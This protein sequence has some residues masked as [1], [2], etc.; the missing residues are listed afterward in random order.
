MLIN[1]RT[2]KLI[3]SI[4]EVKIDGRMALVS[5]YDDLPH[6]EYDLTI[7]NLENSIKKLK[8]LIQELNQQVKKLENENSCFKSLNLILSKNISSL[9]K[10]AKYEIQRKDKI[11]EELRKS[12]MYATATSKMFSYSNSLPLEK[13]QNNQYSNKNNDIEHVITVT[14][15]SNILNENNKDNLT[16]VL[17]QPNYNIPKTVYN[18]RLCKKLVQQNQI[19]ESKNKVPISIQS[20]NIISTGKNT[21]DKN[22]KLNNDKNVIKGMVTPSIHND[23]ENNPNS[24]LI[25]CKSD[26]TSND[27]LYNTTPI[28]QFENSEKEKENVSTESFFTSLKQPIKIKKKMVIAPATIGVPNTLNE[29]LSKSRNLV[30]E[31]IAEEKYTEENNYTKLN[32]VRK[33]SHEICTSPSANKELNSSTRIVKCL[34]LSNEIKSPFLTK[35]KSN[36]LECKSPTI[37]HVNNSTESIQLNNSVEHKDK[38]SRQSLPD[39]TGIPSTNIEVEQVPFRRKT[40]FIGMDNTKTNVIRKSS[41]KAC[42]S[43]SVNKEFNAS[44]SNEIKSPIS[45]KQKNSQLESKSFNII[46]VNNSKESIKLTDSV[47]DS[48]KVKSSRPS[49]PD[50]TSIPSTNIE[51]E[52]VPFKRKTI[53]KEM[54]NNT[55]LNDVK[56]SSHETCTSP[57]VDKKFNISTRVVKCLSLSNEIKS[58]IS[59]KKKNSQF[60][61]KSPTINHV[62]NST[63]SI[64]LNNS[65]EHKDKSSRQSLPDQTGIPSTNIEVEQVPFRRKT[66]FIGMD[67]TKTNVIRKS[68]HKACTSSSVNKE[69]NASPSN[70]I[71]SPISYKQKNSQLESKSF[72]I[73]KVN[74]SK[75]SIKLTDSVDDSSK[76]KSSR[77][78]L[79]DQ[80]SIPS[81]NIE[82][83][84]VPFKRKTIVKEMDNNT[85]LNDVKKSSHET[86]TSPS[87][88]KKFNIST[89]VVKCLSLSNEIKSP[90]SSKKKNS[91]FEC[92]SPTINHVNN[93]TE[94]IQLNDSV[95]RSSKNIS[96]RKNLPEQSSL[97]FTNTEV[98]QVPFKR[99]TVVK[100][101]DNNTKLNDVGKSLHKT[102]TTPTNY[103]E[104]SSSTSIVKSLSPS[105]DIKSPISSKQKNSQSKSPNII[106]VNNSIESIQLNDSVEHSSKEIST[107]I[108]IPSINI[109]VEQGSI[110]RCSGARKVIKHSRPDDNKQE[111]KK[112]K[113]V[114]LITIQDHFS[115]P[116]PSF[117]G[118]KKIDIDVSKNSIHIEK[119]VE[120]SSLFYV[121]LV[122]RRR[123][124]NFG[125]ADS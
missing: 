30:R 122:K 86:C 22:E 53:V 23:L 25:I 60:E 5:L 106:H 68:S 118:A 82:V 93:S 15:K 44:P 107:K 63:E 56:K 90:I 79:P 34:S 78:S 84:Q 73:I 8:N 35:Q 64:Q 12:K 32:D 46:K 102:C 121:P 95:V 29:N 58:P 20:N 110:F 103:K 3:N 105:I 120:S 9:Y 124:M 52:Q 49:L 43:S 115:Q 45:Y 10:T 69:F 26:S 71:K 24:T 57:S 123:T 74:N 54:D 42:T 55:K 4:R 19:N 112:G 38:S 59:S 72:N 2:N 99:K 1:E 17:I 50:Q 21:Q 96:S 48:S 92:K 14:E 116:F 65:V 67:N 97:P 87:V 104:Y 113:H 33:S 13:M 36:Q 76:V 119:V 108:S 101:K 88:D 89:R 51:V 109:E 6:F 81:T 61:C 98:E 16:N 47:D 28:N 27:C 70:E 111:T 94:S 77:P 114:Q 75:E 7:N 85:K 91:Q 11:I 18:T 125:N 40:I 66:I 37:N 83:E 39:Q 117:Y 100:G 41:H 62:N 31:T 80:T